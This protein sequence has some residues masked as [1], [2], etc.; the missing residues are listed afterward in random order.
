VIQGSAVVRGYALVCGSAVVSDSALVCDSAVVSG[1][2]L[3]Y[4]SAVV[5]GSA[6]VSGSALVYDSAVV[7]GSAVIRDTAVICGHGLIEYTTDYLCIGPIGTRQA[8]ITLH[9]D[10]DI[11]IRIVAGCWDGSL[12]QFLA[13]L[14]ADHDDY[15][16]I[17]PAA[18]EIL[19]ARSKTY[20]KASR[21]LEFLA[22]EDTNDALLL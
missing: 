22:V 21:K 14:G 17:V 12:D 4:D 19:R 16:A 5:R 18:W 1:Y 6:V 10:T 9:R 11:G 3:V 2:A 20:E 8:T 15:R 7:R 13:R